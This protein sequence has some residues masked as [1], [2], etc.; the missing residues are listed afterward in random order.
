VG[1]D[2]PLLDAAG[3][4]PPL[5]P[6][7]PLNDALARSLRDAP[8]LQESRARAE[9]SDAR[10]RAIAAELRPDLAL[11][12]TFSG[13]AGTATPSSGS[14]ADQY[15]PLPSVPNWDVG[16]VLRWALYDPVVSARR[17]AAEARAVGAHADLAAL[18]QQERATVQETYVM[19]EVSQAAL[20][21]LDRAVQAARA[22][23]AQAEARF[24]SGLGTSLEIAD[25]E[26]V[27]TESEIQ[28][29]LGRYD[30]NRARAVLAQALGELD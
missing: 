23:Y 14:L 3:D 13:R 9:A 12:A 10:A 24:K 4:P 20:V 27:R 15:G 29:A 30:V 28:L 2:V 26:A 5:S 21:G 7:P 18:T 1:V 19:L 8:A 17:R 16:L 22:N 25:A 6:T 11:T